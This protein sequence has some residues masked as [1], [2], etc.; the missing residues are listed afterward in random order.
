MFASLKAI[1]VAIARPLVAAGREG[2]VR[3]AGFVAE[4]RLNVVLVMGA[5]TAVLFSTALSGGAAEPILLSPPPVEIGPLT[6][7]AKNWAGYVSESNFSSPENYSVT[8]VGGFVDRAAHHAV[9]EFRR[10]LDG[11]YAVGGNR[12]LQQQDG[13]AIGTESTASGSVVTYEAWYEVYPS[14]MTTI[15]EFSRFARRLHHRQR[16]VRRAD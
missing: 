8:A 5:I 16:A 2:K 3:A 12:R 7:T 1:P 10:Y 13:R 14:P 6:F 11:L 15:P 4:S 9:G